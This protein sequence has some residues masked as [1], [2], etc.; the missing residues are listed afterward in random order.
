MKIFSINSGEN[1]LVLPNNTNFGAKGI[2]PEIRDS[3]LKLNPEEINTV[4]ENVSKE[5][6]FNIPVTLLVSYLGL[7]NIFYYDNDKPEKIASNEDSIICYK[8]ENFTVTKYWYDSG[9]KKNEPI[10][11]DELENIY[12]FLDNYISSNPKL[13]KYLIFIDINMP[14]EKVFV[15]L[16]KIN[17]KLYDND[18]IFIQGAYKNKQLIIDFSRI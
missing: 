10:N 8:K 2:S 17:K 16:K 11:N 7:E 5:L 6:P 9:N 1:N 18:Y 12:K 3:F 13:K 14:S 15:R 4:L